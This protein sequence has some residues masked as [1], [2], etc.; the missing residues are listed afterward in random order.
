MALPFKETRSPRFC[1]PR[2]GSVTVSPNW[3][4]LTLGERWGVPG[5]EGEEENRIRIK[6][7]PKGKQGG[8]KDTALSVVY[9]G[10]AITVLTLAALTD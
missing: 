3:L 8:G 9:R 6:E 5:K 2:G 7:G 4:T 1:R 10:T